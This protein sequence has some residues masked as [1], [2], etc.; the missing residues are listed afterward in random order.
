MHAPQSRMIAVSAL[1]LILALAAPEASIAQPTKG[2]E[3][4]GGAAGYSPPIG[5]GP[6]ADSPA[7]PEAMPPPPPDAGQAA[8]AP[9]AASPDGT[10]PDDGTK[11]DDGTLPGPD[12]PD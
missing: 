8:P 7:A 5:T 12:Q 4:T 6:A 2:D 1:A 11:K 10:K 9:D 3:G